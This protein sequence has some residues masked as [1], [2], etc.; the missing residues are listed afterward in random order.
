MMK[1]ILELTCC[2]LLLNN[3]KLNCSQSVLKKWRYSLW[4]Q[5]VYIQKANE[6]YFNLINFLALV[7]SFQ[8][9]TINSNDDNHVSPEKFESLKHRINQEK[10]EKIKPIPE[11][12]GMGKLSCFSCSPPDC[13]NATICHNAVRCQVNSF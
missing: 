11:H 6:F 12:V 2:F 4:R 5:K 7:A 9:E 10:S 8:G 13:R 3:G 1:F